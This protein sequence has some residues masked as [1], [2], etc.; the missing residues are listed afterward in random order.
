MPQAITTA[1]VHRGWFD[2][3]TCGEI[4]PIFY[5]QRCPTCHSNS[6]YSQPTYWGQVI[7]VSAFHRI[8]VSCSQRKVETSEPLPALERYD[9][10]TYRTLRKAMHEGRIPKNLDVLIISAKYG[11][12][13]CQKSIDAYDERMTSVQARNTG[14]SVSTDS[15]C[16]WK[17]DTTTKFSSI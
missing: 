3:I 16:F 12:I 4:L 17:S 13:G 5:H 7:S 10:P 2:C 15:K 11:L 14:M 6:R 9:G 8:T 1:D